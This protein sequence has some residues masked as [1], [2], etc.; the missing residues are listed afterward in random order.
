MTSTRID[1]P[2]GLPFVE[3]THEFNAPRDLLYRAHVDPELLVQWLGPRKY[4]MEIEAMEVRD[5]GRWRFVHKDAEGNE[6]WFHGVH[7]GTP[8]PD[9]ITRTFEFEG[10]PGHVSLESLTFEERGDTTWSAGLGD[11]PV[12]RGPRCDGRCGHGGRRHRWL[13]APRRA[14][15]QARPGPP[16]DNASLA[17]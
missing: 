10:V 16:L 17:A 9:G 11:L 5:G 4:T 3:I 7:H 8:S 2:P 15:R 14:S 1:A 13:P 12:G 6:F